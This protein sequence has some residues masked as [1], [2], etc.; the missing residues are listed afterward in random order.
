MRQ[1]HRQGWGGYMNKEAHKGNT[2]VID[3][4]NTQLPQHLIKNPKADYAKTCLD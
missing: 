4:S 3:Y 2:G 1:Q